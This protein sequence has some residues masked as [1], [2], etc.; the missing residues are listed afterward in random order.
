MY[1]TKATH[2]LEV[3]TETLKNGYRIGFIC[4]KNLKCPKM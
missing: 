4:T 2:E 3:N 1:L